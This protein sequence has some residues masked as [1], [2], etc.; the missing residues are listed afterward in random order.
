MAFL[1]KTMRDP[2]P[3][4]KPIYDA[5]ALFV[6][7]ALRTDDSLF[8]PG[9]PVWALGPIEDFLARF[10]KTSS[11]FKK[12][13]QEALVGAAPLTIQ[14]AA[15]MLYVQLFI[16]VK[17]QGAYKRK[18]IEDILS[19][20]PTRK[21]SI[22]NSLIDALNAELLDEG[23]R[24]KIQQPH[25]ASKR[26]HE[27]HQPRQM[28]SFLEFMCYWK[29]YD[30]RQRMN[31]LED[32]WLFKSIVISPNARSYGGSA[33]RATLLYITFPDTFEPI[34][35]GESKSA[36]ANAPNFKRFIT[37]LSEDEDRRILQIH[38]GLNAEYKKFVHFDEPEIE[39]LWRG[40]AADPRWD[41][42]IHWAKRFHAWAGFDEDE[43]DY[44][45]AVSS[46]LKR[47]VEAVESDA[48]DW[49]QILK[50][51]FGKPNN[52]TPWQMNDNFSKWCQQEPA[53]ARSALLS[54]WGVADPSSEGVSAFVNQTPKTAY[55]GMALVITSFLLMGKLN[56]RQ[57]PIFRKQPFIKGYKLTDYALP[58][59]QATNAVVYEHALHFLDRIITEGAKRD[60]EL[61]D[62]LDAQGVLW[63]ITKSG[64]EHAP[65]S[66]WSEEERQAFLDYQNGVITDD[67]PDGDDL[68]P[69]PT[70]EPPS[71]LAAVAEELLLSEEYLMQI[72]ELLSDKGQVIFYGPPGTGKTYVAQRLAKYYAG[73]AGKVE[74]VQ[75]HPSYAYEDFIEGY[76]PRLINNQPGFE[77]VD[78]PLKRLA[79]QARTRPQ[80]KFLLIIDEINRGNIAKVFGELYFLL[81]YR[82]E[83][84]TLQYASVERTPFNLPRN[85]WI[86]G[87]MNTA[88]RSIALMDA[89]LRRRFHFVKFFPDRLP[90][91][92]ILRDWL[93]KHN[94][95]MAW[96]ADVVDLANK[97]LPD[98]H[99]AIGPSY[100][101]KAGLTLAKMQTIWEY[102]IMP[103]LEEQ[104]F[105]E[106]G[107]LEDFTLDKLC[108]EAGIRTDNISDGSGKSD[109]NTETKGV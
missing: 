29:K 74:L 52:L 36:I 55:N 7:K 85:V 28:K 49:P 76:R 77:L 58:P 59:K 73:S 6:N 34:N 17:K 33:Q 90:I 16:L 25:Q 11:G 109:E 100:F 43:R 103:L 93:Q 84:V 61:R 10:A 69:P 41:S 31:A 65:V 56:P 62:R 42:F 54:L 107:R 80:D 71:T 46:N 8:T 32:P 68:P 88:D 2:N 20:T 14:L 35:S 98:R 99:A 86:I 63:K 102:A 92:N 15:E 108:L 66:E 40:K 24:Y 12:S 57:Y 106:E 47:A 101:L 4:L 38:A 97:R 79:E 3:N 45:L 72:E 13:L 89:A 70:P 26:G 81:E 67:E 23:Q 105:G 21:V 37:E 9:Q 39:S 104:F 91:Q 78:G 95:G 48:A 64:A 5:A 82:N 75:F 1:T 53:A 96:V 87:T 27:T 18:E 19:L 44:K 51:A 50:Q 94:P 30:S 83:E 60:L 22:P